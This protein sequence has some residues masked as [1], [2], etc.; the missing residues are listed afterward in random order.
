MAFLECWPPVGFFVVPFPLFTMCCPTSPSC[1]AKLIVRVA[2]GGALALFGLAHLKTISDFTG[3]VSQGLG[4]LSG[5]GTLWAY[6]LPVLMIV[7]GV[8]FIVNY[9]TDIATWAAGVALASIIVGMPLKSV[10]GNVPLGEVGPGVNNAFLWL[11]VYLFVVKCLCPHGKE[12]SEKQ[13]EHSEHS[14]PTC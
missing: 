13:G 3:M 2:F 9:R 7:G 5:L 11:L 4:P 8:L 10:V 12:G 6:V 1:A 14:C